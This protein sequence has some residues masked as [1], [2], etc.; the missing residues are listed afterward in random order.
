MLRVTVFAVSMFLHV[1]YLCA[2]TAL[3]FHRTFH[4][5]LGTLGLSGF[6]VWAAGVLVGHPTLYLA[7]ATAMFAS[8]I[9]GALRATRHHPIFA[10]EGW[11]RLL[12]QNGESR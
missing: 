5:M 10:L 9:L 7:G 1:G 11:V 3:P 2:P 6:A 12:S 8:F 4:R